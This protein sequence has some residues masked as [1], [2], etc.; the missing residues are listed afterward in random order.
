[1]LKNYEDITKAIKYVE[2]NIHDERV[3]QRAILML[4]ELRGL[5][6]S[7]DVPKVKSETEAASQWVTDKDGDSEEQRTVIFKAGDDEREITRK[8]A[9]GSLVIGDAF[10]VPS[11]SVAHNY[12]SGIY[13]Q[14]HGQKKSE[15]KVPAVP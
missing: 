4:N 14:K 5:R 10:V 2:E 9:R 12:Y 11:E 13:S 15:P 3:Q 8:M 7:Y 1:M 6:M